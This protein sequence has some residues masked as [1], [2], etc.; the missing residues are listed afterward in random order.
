MKK[1]YHYERN[2][3]SYNSLFCNFSKCGEYFYTNDK[4][5]NVILFHEN[6]KV[7]VLFI[8]LLEKE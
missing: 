1:F 7:S 5:K 8:Q 2:L 6:I 4:R 3:L